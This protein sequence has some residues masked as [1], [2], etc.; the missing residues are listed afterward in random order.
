MRRELCRAGR[1]LACIEGFV[2][3]VLGAFALSGCYP[4]LPTPFAEGTEVLGAGKVGLTVVGAGGYAQTNQPGTQPTLGT[5]GGGLEARVRVGVGAKQE[6]GASFIAAIGTGSAGSDPPFNVGGLVT[7]KIAP[8]EWFALVADAGVLSVNAASIVTW[9]GD[10]AAIFAPY[11]AKDGSQVYTGARGGFAVPM[12]TNQNAH[13]VSEAV[14]V[15]LGYALQLSEKTRLMFEAGFVLGFTQLTHEF[16]PAVTDNY[17]SY[18]GYGL[19]GFRYVF[20]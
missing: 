18:G 14:T 17:T 5:G 7:Y 13:A 12:L 6:V 20:N 16:T 1:R 11:T 8:V 2:A 19:F 10:L 4:T 9:S 3:S 15:P